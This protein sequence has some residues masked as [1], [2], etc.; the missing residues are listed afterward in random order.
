MTGSKIRLN[1]EIINELGAHF[2]KIE[3][4]KEVSEKILAAISE[5]WEERGVNITGKK[6]VL[7]SKPLENLRK[8]DFLKI[9]PRN[10]FFFIDK[11]SKMRENSHVRWKMEE[12]N[13][14]DAF[15]FAA[16]PGVL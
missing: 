7:S 2:N 3:R 12:K 1:S 4:K 8:K 9:F 16:F 11:S 14:D 5:L 6:A 13:S 15:F 10:V